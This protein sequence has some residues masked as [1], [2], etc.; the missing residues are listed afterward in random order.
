MR[1]SR[2]VKPLASYIMTG[3]MHA[4]TAVVGFA[5]LAFLFPPSTLFSGA[6]LALVTLR[7]GAAHGLVVLGGST[8]A[9]LIISLLTLGQIWTGLAYSVSQWTPLMIFALI[10]RYTVSLSLTL[11]IA[12]A[13]GL[14][15]VLGVHLTLPD[16]TQY[17]MQLLD[18]YLRPTMIQAQIP[19]TSI[20]S[21]FEKAAQLM[22]G[23]F[24]SSML[25]SLAL[26]LMLARWW[27]SLLYNPGG[28]RD[29]FIDLR[30]GTTA[31]VVALGLFLAAL[32]TEN[33]LFTELAMVSVAL[34]FLQGVAIIHNI[35]GRTKNPIIWLV[36]FY[37]ILIFALIQMVA[38]VCALGVI[39]T[40][41]N[42]RARLQ[43]IQ[44]KLK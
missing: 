14:L 43:K 24:I 17:W 33:H 36:G 12:I 8:L 27:Q 21:A 25:L 37:V 7:L 3:R 26:N 9:M 29:E 22:T 6:A 30:L 28:F 31:G 4:I 40:F 23:A 42:I 10:L 38:G 41:T 5:A 18:Q 16:S 13:L 39:D 2:A 20:D 35:S 32:L 44:H 19:A 11:Q 1:Y 34:F 15:V